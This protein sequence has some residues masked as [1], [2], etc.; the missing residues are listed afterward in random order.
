MNNSFTLDL[1]DLTFEEL[2]N[3]VDN[4]QDYHKTNNSKDFKIEFNIICT[5]G[6]LSENKYAPI[7]NKINWRGN[8]RYDL[9][10]WGKDNVPEKGCTFT[11]EDLILLSDA[12]LA[13]D[14]NIKLN[15]VLRK[16]NKGRANATFYYRIAQLNKFSNKKGDWIKEVNII[17]WGYGGDP[18]VDFR[19]WSTDYSTCMK[20]I[21]IS[22]QEL[23]T[24][25]NMIES[26]LLED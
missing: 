17:D 14:F 23:K 5:Y 26:V 7:F 18:K 6:A 13:F 1:D 21:C 4:M 25:K 8:E 9:R 24:F 10:R 16:Y 20:G 11:K 12:L 2:E 15:N 19:T 3:S 22:L